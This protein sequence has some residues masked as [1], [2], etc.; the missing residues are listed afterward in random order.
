MIVVVE[1]IHQAQYYEEI[2]TQ[3][4]IEGTDTWEWHA[5]TADG[6]VIIDKISVPFF[7][8]FSF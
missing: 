6:I 8:K 2:A 4:M 5:D 1:R 7:S 3:P